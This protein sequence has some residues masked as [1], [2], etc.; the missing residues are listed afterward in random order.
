[1]KL[2][3]GMQSNQ[4]DFGFLEKS[5]QTINDWITLITK[6]IQ[7]LHQKNM[8]ITWANHMRRLFINYFYYTDCRINGP[9]SHKR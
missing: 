1:M 6:N 2:R 7:L 8:K 3:T 9:R 5:N 4:R